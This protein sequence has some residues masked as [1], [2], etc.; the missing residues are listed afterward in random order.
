MKLKLNYKRII[1]IVVSVSLVLSILILP[2][3]VFATS[4]QT[5]NLI[6][7]GDFELGDITG[8]IP[9]Q[10]ISVVD[11]SSTSGVSINSNNAFF[12]EGNELIKETE[13]T[14]EIMRL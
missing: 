13:T 8:F 4:S 10:N 9:N 2:K 11:T 1:S 3:S 14:I 5:N 7:N 6:Q 12:T